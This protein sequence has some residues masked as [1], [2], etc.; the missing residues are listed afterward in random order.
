MAPPMHTMCTRLPAFDLAGTVALVTC[1]SRAATRARCSSA[2]NVAACS[3]AIAVS[4]EASLIRSA[5]CLA[6][7]HSAEYSAASRCSGVP[8]PNHVWS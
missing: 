5:P 2:P 4:E 6:A 1:V 7:R 3:Y 8:V